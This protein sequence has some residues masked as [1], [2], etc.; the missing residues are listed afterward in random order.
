[1]IAVV[2]VRSG[3]LPAGA[4]EAVA[5]CDGRAMLVGTGTVEAAAGLA[6]VSA[7]V[8]CAEL[9]DAPLATGGAGVFRPAALA[10]ALAGLLADEPMVVLPASPDGRDLAPRLAALL[11]RPLWAG[12]VQVTEARVDL[13]RNGSTELHRVSPGAA[14]VAT[15]QP[16]VR[17]VAVAAGAAAPAIVQ[18]AVNLGDLFEIDAKVTEVLPPDPATIDLA[19]AERIVGGGAGLDSTERM[20]QLSR[21]GLALGASMGATRVVTD[22]GWAPH[23]RQIGTTG[24]VIDPDLYLA[25]GISGAV[26]HTSGLGNPQHI[27]SV[28]TDGHCPMMQLADLA[29]TADANATLAELET[30]LS[31][32][33]G[34]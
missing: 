23:A 10:A 12:A 33:A 28:N 4:A 8:A 24:V 5:E 2:V 34:S 1:M 16:G 19:E 11:H 30:L 14:F 20:A 25:F 17:G 21:V 31:S 18:V 26:Q 6:G 3:Q 22:R 15:L 29:I 27:I 13:A 32:G 7:E 9:G